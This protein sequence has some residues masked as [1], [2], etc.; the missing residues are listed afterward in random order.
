MIWEIMTCKL[1]LVMQELRLKIEEGMEVMVKEQRDI[2]DTEPLYG[3]KSSVSHLYAS[4]WR[5]RE[6][7][8]KIFRQAGACGKV[9]KTPTK[10]G[11]G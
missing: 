7:K 6:T 3:N 9:G 4:L 11:V 5:F 2:Q 1:S 10:K 8:P